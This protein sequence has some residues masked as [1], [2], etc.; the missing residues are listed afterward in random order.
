MFC[1][2]SVLGA[3]P[4]KDGGARRCK[5]NGRK[6]VEQRGARAQG[7]A[8]SGRTAEAAISFMRLFVSSIFAVVSATSFLYV[9]YRLFRWPTSPTESAGQVRRALGLL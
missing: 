6:G 1:R 9:S 3:P 8:P 2:P 5:C 4:K 7:L